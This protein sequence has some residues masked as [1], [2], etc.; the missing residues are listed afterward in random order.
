MV[1]G[2]CETGAG[3]VCYAVVKEEYNE[4]GAFDPEYSYGCF[5][6]SEEGFLQ[7]NIFITYVS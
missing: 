4:T 3:G 6:P 1:N 7:V 2:T 5:A